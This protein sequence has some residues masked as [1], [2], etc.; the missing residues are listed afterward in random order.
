M[1][2]EIKMLLHRFR[3]FCIAVERECE[4]DES[5]PD[6]VPDIDALDALAEEA[7]GLRKAIND[8]LG[9]DE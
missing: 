6:A 8:V 5:E 9:E 2:E 1:N 7:F 3:G 4:K